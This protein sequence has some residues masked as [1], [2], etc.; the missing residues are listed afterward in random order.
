MKAKRIIKILVVAILA[1]S[2]VALNFWYENVVSA[3]RQLDPEVLEIDYSEDTLFPGNAVLRFEEGSPQMEVISQD[4]DEYI[5]E[6]KSGRIWGNFSASNSKVNIIVGQVVLIPNAANFDVNFD[7]SRIDLAVYGGDVY[8]GFLES[9]TISIE[10]YHDWFSP[11]FVNKLLV[12]RETQVDIPLSKIGEHLNVLLYSKLVKEFKYSAISASSYEEEWVEANMKA[13]KRYRDA[14]KQSFSS[15]IFDEGLQVVDGVVDESVFALQEKLTLVPEQRKALLLDNLFKY[16][17]DAIYYAASADT[18]NSQ[19]MMA[20]FH[21]YRSNLD[22]EVSRSNDYYSRVDEYVDELLVFSPGD[23]EYEIFRSLLDK[24][25]S[26][27]RERYEVV[28]MLWTDVYEAIEV[29]DLVA[30]R[31]LDF[32]YDNFTATVGEYEDPDYYRDYIAYQNQLFDTLF[33]RQS[34]FYRDAYF[35]IKGQLELEL[36]SLYQDGQLK[37]ELR[38]AFVSQK[39]DFLKRLRNFFFAEEIGVA[40]SNQILERLVEEVNDLM[41]DSSSDLAVADF[42]EDRLEDISDF[43]GYLNAPEYNSSTAY[44][45]THEE[46]YATYLEEKDVI[47]SFIG[48][49]EDVLGENVEVSASDVKKEIAEV[50]AGLDL[51]SDLEIGVID[52]TTQ[53]YV[54]VEGILGGY[55]FS[56]DFDRDFEAVRDIYVYGELISDSPVQVTEMLTLFQGHF[57]D[58]SDL[59]EI[60]V[61]ELDEET[62]AQIGARVYLASEFQKAG[63]AVEMDNVAVINQADALYRITEISHPNYPD[64]TLTFDFAMT[65][66]KALNIFLRIDGSPKTIEESYTIEELIELLAFEDDLYSNPPVDQQEDRKVLR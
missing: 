42:F 57:S 38:Q 26:E 41:R 65:Q 21:A 19:S 31:A 51:L 43:W 47:S 27:G 35:E 17:D 59:A 50:F 63:F 46:R 18:E 8:V 61:D 25:F 53:R 48:L 30:E 5:V 49:Q 6:L 66:E 23:D 52:D 16:L 60:E 3:S 1:I 55:P 4:R 36:I 39:I 20:Q 14:L 29:N 11:I 33:L 13:D 24:N 56:G 15:E 2:V 37:D 34:L 58:I 7:G 45:E 54:E 32:Y 12:P 44:G 62:N 28:N 22:V 10:R 64:I 9:E 40:E